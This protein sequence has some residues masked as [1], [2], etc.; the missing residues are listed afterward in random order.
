MKVISLQLA[1]QTAILTIVFF[2]AGRADSADTAIAKR[3]GLQA[4]I[5]YCTDCHGLSG[6]GYH[7]FYPIPRLAGQPTEYFETQLR[8]FVEG[9]RTNPI[10]SNAARA[11]SPSMV[12][13]LA[14]HFRDLNPRPIGDG[15]MNL[16]YT[17]K[18][19][20]EKGI[21]ESNVP[22]CVACHG[23]EAQG[24]EAIPRLAG[25]PLS[26]HDKR[27]AELEQR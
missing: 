27:V 22:A 13:A 19:I 21:P 14:A 26:V 24:Q 2:V 1:L 11:L 12:T 5:E 7:G 8:A 6:Q 16:V 20:F 15:P 10:M 9:R 4:K 23:P 18:T 3:A 17:G 25:Q